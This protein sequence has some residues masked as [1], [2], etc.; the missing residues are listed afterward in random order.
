MKISLRLGLSFSF[1]LVFMIVIIFV[2]LNRIK[3]SKEMYVRVIE[4]NAVRIQLANTMINHIREVSIDSANILL[5]KD[6]TKT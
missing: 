5:L 3:A 4:V 2:S 6:N 1:I